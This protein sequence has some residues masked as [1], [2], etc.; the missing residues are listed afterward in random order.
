MTRLPGYKDRHSLLECLQKI[1]HQ[2]T[3]YTTLMDVL[4]KYDK[5]EQ[6]AETVAIMRQFPA[7]VDAGVFFSTQ[8]IRLAT[9]L[10]ERRRK[11]TDY[12]G[13]SC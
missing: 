3:R 1:A 8:S 4:K 2:A 6:C 7:D 13:Y 12:V 5:S 11:C 9:I 10:Q